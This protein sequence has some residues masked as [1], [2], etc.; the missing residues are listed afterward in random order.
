[1]HGEHFPGDPWSCLNL[2]YH[3]IPLLPYIICSRIGRDMVDFQEGPEDCHDEPEYIEK[4]PECKVEAKV[5]VSEL[6]GAESQITVKF[7]SNEAA[8]Q[9]VIAKVKAR[10]DVHTNDMFT[11]SLDMNKCHFFD[12]ETE[13][14]IK[15]APKKR[16]TELEIETGAEEAEAEEAKAE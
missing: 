14:R 10:T 2:P 12:P 13:L 4:H 3:V 15:P 11:M 5:E 8:G 16:N 1:M 7:P 6:L 9:M